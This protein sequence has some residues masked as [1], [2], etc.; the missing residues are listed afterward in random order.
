M[1]IAITGA[2]GQLGRLVVEKL[3]ARIG[4]DPILALARSP[5]K[6]A[7][8]GVEVRAF[9]YNAADT[10][11]PALAGVDQLLLISGSEIGQRTVQHKAVIAAAKAAGV[12]HIAYTSVLHGAANPAPVTPEHVATEDALA[13]S[14]IATTLLRNGWYMENYTMGMAAA[15]EHGALIGASGDARISAATREDYA[16]AAVAVLTDPAKQGRT[17]E[18][19]GDDA[20]TMAEAAGE[21]SRQSG[22]DIPYVD[23][24]EADYAAALAQTGMPPE[25][26]SFL[27]AMDTGTATGAL[28]DDG[29][30][31]SGLIGRATTPLSAVVADLL[32]ASSS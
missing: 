21:L 12:Q 16:D 30:A 28:F 6:A 23:M 27:A 26:A 4:A 1:T 15:L 3:K 7:D 31:L 24:T 17:Y 14:G 32:G 5:E 29:K 10:L 8:L 11:A 13:A 20:F 18:L 19:A 9:D 22:K 2:T 25:F